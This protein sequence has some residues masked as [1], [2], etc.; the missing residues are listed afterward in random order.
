MGR[1]SSAV[2][3]DDGEGESG[4]GLDISSEDNSEFNELVK[5]GK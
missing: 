2:T 3:H 5:I 4:S 1:F